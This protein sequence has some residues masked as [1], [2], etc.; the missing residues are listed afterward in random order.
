MKVDEVMRISKTKH[1]RK[2]V[3]MPDILYS[4]EC[5]I[6]DDYPVPSQDTVLHGIRTFLQS[7]LN[8]DPAPIGHDGL[9]VP[10]DR[11]RTDP[12]TP[13]GTVVLPLWEQSEKF[14]TTSPHWAAFNTFLDAIV[15][16]LSIASRKIQE[17]MP[18]AFASAL[19]LAFITRMSVPNHRSIRQRSMMNCFESVRLSA[20]LSLKPAQ[21]GTT[22]PSQ[23]V[24]TM[25]FGESTDGGRWIDTV[26]RLY[27]NLRPGIV[28][29]ARAEA[30]H[31]VIWFEGE[32]FQLEF[33][34]AGYWSS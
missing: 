7:Y 30:I 31:T 10:D 28:L 24:A 22:H 33:L 4:V 18:E 34:S 11:P 2:Q 32:Y 14:N 3:V 16:A 8:L 9:P 26:A 21:I 5:S 23:M 25:L 20:N 27:S 17:H 1:L 15:P 29:R 6:P 19:A 12:S 13:Y